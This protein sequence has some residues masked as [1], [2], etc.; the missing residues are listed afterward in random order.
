MRTLASESLARGVQV[1]LAVARAHYNNINYEVLGRGYPADAY[2]DSE[3]DVFQEEVIPS[4]R[5]LAAIIKKTYAP[6]SSSE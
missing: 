3:L 2:S 6:A 5:A 1:T 4:A